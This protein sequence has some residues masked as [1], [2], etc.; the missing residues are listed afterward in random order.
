VVIIRLCFLS[1]TQLAAGRVSFILSLHVAVSSGVRWVQKVLMCSQGCVSLVSVGLI[2]VPEPI[3]MSGGR[4]RGYINWLKHR[5]NAYHR[6]QGYGVSLKHMAR[7]GRRRRY[8][9]K[10]QVL[11][12]S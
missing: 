12:R 9:K 5:L 4:E 10:I 2:S 11:G 3:T 1:I 8:S 7:E 6:N